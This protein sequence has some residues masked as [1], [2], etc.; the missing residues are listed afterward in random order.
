MTKQSLSE[1]DVQRLLTDPSVETR[2]ATAAKIAADFDPGALS[3]K[4]RQMAEEIFRVMVK[5]AEVRVREALADNL[6]E[7]AAVPHDVAKA[8]AGD[9]DSVALPV[10]EFSK[11]LSDQDLI[12]IVRSQGPAKQVAIAKRDV[13]SKDLSGA[14]V[15]AGNEKAVTTLVANEGAEISERSLAKV[16][17]DFGEVEAVQN[18]MVH[19]PKLPVAISERLVTMVSEN[20]KEELAKRHEISTDMATDLILQSRERATISLGSLGDESDLEKL[21]KQLHDN[22]R[23]TPSIITRALCMGDLSFFEASLAMLSG[24]SLANAR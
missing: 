19:R 17:D 20:L 2:A 1:K 24:T 3:D 15:D 18:A 23:L 8:L 4:E 9:V 13:V 5:D 21:I 16:V 22:G 14:L 6:K 11:V 10:L 7:N 12:E